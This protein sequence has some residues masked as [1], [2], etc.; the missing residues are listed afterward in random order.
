MNLQ[1]N[2]AYYLNSS[3]DGLPPERKLY[4]VPG[5][6]RWPGQL[7][8]CTVRGPWKAPCPNFN[9]NHPGYAPPDKSNPGEAAEPEAH[10]LYVY[11]RP[12]T[13]VNWCLNICVVT[14]EFARLISG[15]RLSGCEFRLVELFAKSSCKEAIEGY[16]ELRVAGR[17]PADLEGPGISVEY[18]CEVSGAIV[19][20]PWRKDTG[21]RFEGDPKHWPDSFKISQMP[22]MNFITA[23]FAQFLIDSGADS[24]SLIDASML[25]PWDL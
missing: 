7:A 2:G 12:F 14:A 15:Q 18:Q 19:Y 25:P 5:G 24:L 16:L 4:R 23:R 20:S 10:Q 22:G 8:E 1:P 13:T 3:P 21:I 11:S 6:R 17:V 9:D